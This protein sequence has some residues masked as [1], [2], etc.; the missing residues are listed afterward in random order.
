MTKTRLQRELEAQKAGRIAD[1]AFSLACARLGLRI[2]E[3]LPAPIALIALAQ[4]ELL[5]R[6]EE[7]RGLH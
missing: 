7:K 4:A 3:T 5:A 6:H 1:A 2:K